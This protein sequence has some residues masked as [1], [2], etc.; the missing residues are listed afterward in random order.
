E[1]TLKENTVGVHVELPVEVATYLIN[2]KRE[3]IIEIEKRHSVRILLIPNE[4]MTTPNYRIERIRA[5]DEVNKPDVASYQ[6]ADRSEVEKK[7]FVSTV[8]S[9]PPAIQP[10]QTPSTLPP[11][12]ANKSAPPQAK[13]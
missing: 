8:S 3:A 13:P 11:F 7:V 10:V 1:E 9:E 5:S 6:L 12:P 4:T 2:E